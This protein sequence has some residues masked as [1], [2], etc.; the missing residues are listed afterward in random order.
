M[1]LDLL[2]L[3]LIAALAAH[4]AWRGGFKT[5][6]GLLGL[7]AGYAAAV[8]GAAPLARP[9][10]AA[11]GMPELLALP[12]AGSLLFLAGF[13]GV[14]LLGFGLGRAGIGLADPGPRGR[15][16][17]AIF[18]AVRGALIAVLVAYL[19]LW[20]D[21][22][23]ATGRELPLPPVEDSAAARVTGTLVEAGVQAALSDSGAA[24]RVVARAAARPA[25]ALTEWQ[26]VVDTPS[27]QAL[28]EDAVFWSYVELENLDAALSRASA[29]HLL[30]D[31]ELRERL[32]DLGVVSAAAA[33][34]PAIF[35]DDLIAVLREVGPRV[36]GLR[37][38]PALQELM[39]DPEVVAMA[40]SGDTMGLLA[41]P[42]FRALV[43][44]VAARPATP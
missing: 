17:G 6:M 40:Q 22:L 15:F 37:D 34:D 24:A 2:A 8:L 39:Q 30:R 10:S 28:R 4:G 33:R 7:A 44:R 26:A 11:L 18:G 43:E 9:L 14:W 35:R 16:L 12:L 19:G 41:H 32:A 20:L 23:R 42:G 36:R 29:L 1:W 5:G 31:D 21:A 25:R 38:D 3:V 27:V 13:V